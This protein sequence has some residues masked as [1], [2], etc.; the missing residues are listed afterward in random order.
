MNLR[1]GL[2]ICL[3]GLAL[4]PLP[5]WSQQ[6]PPAAE[7]APSSSRGGLGALL[8]GVVDSVNEA[9]AKLKSQ[10]RSAPTS[11]A[12]RSS[13]AA[14]PA[15]ADSAPRGTV[16]SA[17]PLSALFAKH[18][19][20]GTAKSH[21][22]RVAVTVRDWKSAS[23]WLFDARIWW[24]ASRSEKLSGVSVCWRDS[25]SRAADNAVNYQLFMRQLSVE[26]SGNVRTEGP[27]P[28]M[29]A[30][31]ADPFGVAQYEKGQ[32]AIS[33]IQQLLIE[34]GWQ[35]GAPTNLWIVKY[36]DKAAVAGGEAPQVSGVR[37][38]SER[39]GRCR[40]GDCLQG[41]AEAR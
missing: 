41:G 14:A 34:T 26:H 7:S 3:L 40:K 39:R 2:L 31:A 38:C 35:P 1:Q 16:L 4:S 22:P 11:T 27:K 30:Y 8:K 13:S 23:C 18:P 32:Q 24:S 29:M 28:P 20:D 9:A 17:T 10:P 6:A 25:L 37:A 12:S 15:L 19:Y 5:V 33:F 21:F 36:D